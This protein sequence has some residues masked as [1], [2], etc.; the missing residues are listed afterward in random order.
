MI[1]HWSRYHQLYTILHVIFVLRSASETFQA[2]YPP[3]WDNVV[4]HH[5]TL[6]S[7]HGITYRTKSLITLGLASIT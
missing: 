1:S 7:Y 5:V 4:V 3:V 2:Q 6:N